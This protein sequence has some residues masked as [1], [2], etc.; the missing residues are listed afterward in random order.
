MGRTKGSRNKN[1]AQLP[2]YCMLSIEERALM[3]AELI[4]EQIER[5]QQGG[6]TLLKQIEGVD[7]R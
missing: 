1:S 5:D 4:V 2:D 7:V 6:G 3:I